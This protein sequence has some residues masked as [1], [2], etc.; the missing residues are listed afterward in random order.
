MNP[1][2]LKILLELRNDAI[3]AGSAVT[4][5][6][7]FED[8]IPL[9]WKSALDLVVGGRCGNLLDRREFFRACGVLVPAR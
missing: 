4:M 3:P 8:D 2:L 6:N 5:K 7:H 1:E 9:F